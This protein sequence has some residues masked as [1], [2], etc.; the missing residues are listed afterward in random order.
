M[1]DQGEG[2]VCHR[3]DYLSIIPIHDTVPRM[4]RYAKIF[5]FISLV[6]GLFAVAGKGQTQANSNRI[7][8]GQ[9]KTGTVPLTGAIVKVFLTVN[10]KG[11]FINL[12]PA[13]LVIDTTVNP[14]VLKSIAGSGG[15]T[16]TGVFTNQEFTAADGQT[17]FILAGA[18]QP[19]STVRVFVNGL[20]ERAL[21]RGVWALNGA[22]IVFLV[23]P[24]G[25]SIIEVEY[26]R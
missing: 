4:G 11:A 23:P 13:T 24:G 6:G 26:N 1:G 14:P 8:P 25:G 16:P 20:K 10:D 15:G 18:P 5:L 21:G 3:V 7:D 9:L 12:D 19:N 17:N 2:L 22:T